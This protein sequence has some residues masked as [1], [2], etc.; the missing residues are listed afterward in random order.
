MHGLGY[1][2]ERC[3]DLSSCNTANT[4]TIQLST[5]LLIRAD[6]GAKRNEITRLATRGFLLP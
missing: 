1:N 5:Q 3:A 4:N 6:L 2:M